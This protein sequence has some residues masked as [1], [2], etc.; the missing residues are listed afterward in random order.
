MNFQVINEESPLLVDELVE[1]VREFI[2]YSMILSPHRI[3]LDNVTQHW[4]NDEP[5]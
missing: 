5:V 2:V 4:L 1:G 3:R